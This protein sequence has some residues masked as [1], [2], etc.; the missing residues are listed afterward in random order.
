M[1][2]WSDTCETITGEGMGGVERQYFLCVDVHKI[3]ELF[4]FLDKYSLIYMVE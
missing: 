2:L 3:C 4:F 1:I